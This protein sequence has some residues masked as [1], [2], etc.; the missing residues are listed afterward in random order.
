MV[1]GYASGNADEINRPRQDKKYDSNIF[2]K[3]MTRC[4]KTIV[5]TLYRL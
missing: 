5:N 4:D 2:A 1:I 3:L